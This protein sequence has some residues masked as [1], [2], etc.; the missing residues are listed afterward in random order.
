MTQKK[1]TLTLSYGL[2]RK[3]VHFRA[4]QVFDFALYPKSKNQKSQ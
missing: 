3:N 4:F 1:K 2:R